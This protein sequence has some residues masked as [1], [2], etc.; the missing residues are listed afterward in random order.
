MDGDHPRE[1]TEAATSQGACPVRQV[2]VRGL[3]IRA[4]IGVHDH[5]R[6]D[7]QLVRIDIELDV[8]DERDHGD[9]LERVVCYQDIVDG[10]RAIV[11]RGHINLV[12]TLAG[13]IADMALA[14]P[15]VFAARVRVEKPDAIADAD[16]AGVAIERRRTD[17]PAGLHDLR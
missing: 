14:D 1:L 17:R 15:R 16:G 12:E 9:R 7:G 8:A 4:R 3:A 11:A 13:H 10:V 6:R 5:E 2:F